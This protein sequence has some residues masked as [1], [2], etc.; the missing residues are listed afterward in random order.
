[1]KLRLVD[2]ESLKKI[3]ADNIPERPVLIQ[4]TCRDCGCDVTIE[5]H[6]TSGGFGLQGGVLLEG[7]QQIVADCLGCYAKH[8]VENV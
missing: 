4:R 2:L 5:L 6:K 3:F 1:M 8:K 7:D